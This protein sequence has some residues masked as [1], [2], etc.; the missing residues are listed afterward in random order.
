[1]EKCSGSC[2]V[3]GITASPDPASGAL[4]PAPHRLNAGWNVLLI[5]GVGEGRRFSLTLVNAED[6]PVRE[7]RNSAAYR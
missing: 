2:A 5:K 4:E 6:R 7:L 1:M 3:S